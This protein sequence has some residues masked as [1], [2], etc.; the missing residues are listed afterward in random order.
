MTRIIR[1]SSSTAPARATPPG[2]GTRVI[3]AARLA[4]QREAESILERAQ[5][6]AAALLDHA[7]SEAE[8]LRVRVRTEVQAEAARRLAEL[9]LRAR[10]QLERS[11]ADLHALAIGIAERILHGELRQHPAHVAGVVAAC[12]E[13]A[14]SA[15]EVR[16]KVHPDDVPEV[17]RSLPPGAS[18]HA[19]PAIARGGCLIET[20]AGQID[21]RLETQ[22]AA[23]REALGR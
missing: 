1:A 6:E 3:H 12:L 8:A 14:R 15:R 9:E 22:L 16:I 18:V 11:Q 23:V 17:E 21:G 2:D 7:R 4:A 13:G 5:R 19:D 10:E 20:G